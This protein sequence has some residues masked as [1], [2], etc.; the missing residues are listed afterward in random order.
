M[1][2]K[3]L[4]L[5]CGKDYRE[6]GEKIEWVN[7]DCCRKIKA[8]IYTDLEKKLPFEDNTFD[9]VYTSHVLEHV[10]KLNQ[11]MSELKRICKKGSIIEIR[12]PHASCMPTYQD[13]THVRFFTYMTFDYFTDW[14]FYDSP[15]FKIVSK[16]L[17]YTAERW[18]FLNYIFNPLINISPTYYERLFGWIFPCAEIKCKLMVIK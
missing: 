7:L 8:D 9:G 13:P 17:N 2:K 16:S 10:S 5:G 15:K 14:N 1:K 18:K 6:S 11:L 4:N 3:I 12:V